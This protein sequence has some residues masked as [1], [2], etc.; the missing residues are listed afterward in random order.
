MSTDEHAT[1]NKRAA[2]QRTHPRI[3]VSP[4]NDHLNPL[5]VRA[6]DHELLLWERPGRVANEVQKHIG[7]AFLQAR[8]LKRSA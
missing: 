7:S 1:T 8:L 4:A 5:R 2:T 6:E 3:S